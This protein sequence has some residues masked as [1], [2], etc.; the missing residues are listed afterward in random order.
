MMRTEFWLA[1]AMAM[2]LA[3]GS[4]SAATAGPTLTFTLKNHRFTPSSV[5]APAGQV[6]QVTLIN[7]D[8]ATEEFDSHDLKV[9][10][11]V[12]PRGKA[13]FRIGPLKPGVYH[14]MGEFHAETAQG[15][16]TVTP[17]GN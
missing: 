12:T 11:L 13:L 2:A 16:I 6:I 4:A 5:T 15:V 3:T 10:K 9:E 8:L 14:F 1:M 17:Q 7:E